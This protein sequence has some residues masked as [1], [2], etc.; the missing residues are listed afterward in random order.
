M[1]RKNDEVDVRNVYNWVLNRLRFSYQEK[2]NIEDLIERNDE[3]NKEAIE[4]FLSKE[5]DDVLLFNIED[6]KIVLKKEENIKFDDKIV[7][8]HKYMNGYIKD[9]NNILY[10]ILSPNILDTLKIMLLKVIY[11]LFFNNKNIYKNIC[12]DEINKFSMDFDV[13][14][15]ELN[16]FILILEDIKKVKK[17]KTYEYEIICEKNGANI[18]NKNENDEKKENSNVK[19]NNKSGNEIE[20]KIQKKKTETTLLTKYLNIIECLFNDMQHKIEEYKKCNFDVGPFIEIQYW[21]YKHRYL[22]FIIEELKSSEIKNIINN[23]NINNSNNEEQKYAYTFDILNKWR[24]LE[25]KIEN[26]Y[27]ESKDN[28]KY[29]ESI[30]QFILSLYLCNVEN[31]IDNIPSLLN[32]IKMIYLVARFY[33]TPNKLNN[34]FIKITNQLVLKC[35]NEIFFAKKKKKKNFRKSKRNDKKNKNNYEYTENSEKYNRQKDND[36]DSSNNI[37]ED[38]YLE[39]G[40]D[41]IRSSNFNKNKNNYNKKEYGYYDKHMKNKN[42]EMSLDGNNDSDE[43]MEKS[44]SSFDYHDSEN[45]EQSD[46]ENSY[47]IGDN[48]NEE[49]EG[50]NNKICGENIINMNFKMDEMTKDKENLWELDPDELIEKFEL[51]FKL[52]EKYKEEFNNIKT[53]F[54]NNSKNKSVNLDTQVIFCKMDLFCRRLKKLVD[55]FLCIKQFKELKKVKFNIIQNITTSFNKYIK[56]FKSKHIDDMLNYTDNYFDRDFVELRVY[57]SELE[58]DLQES[59][60]NLLNGSSNIMFSFFIFFKFKKCFMRDYLINFLHTKY[61][62]LLAQFLEILNSINNDLEHYKINL[63]SNKNINYLKNIFWIISIN[64][65]INHIIKIFLDENNLMLN[66]LNQVSSHFEMAKLKNAN[67]LK[68]F[69]KPLLN[70]SEKVV[71]SNGISGKGIDKN[72]CIDEKKE[73]IVCRNIF[74]E[75]NEE[76]LKLLEEHEKKKKNDTKKKV[77]SEEDGKNDGEK[78]CNEDKLVKIEESENKNKKIKNMIFKCSSGKEVLKLYIKIY[79]FIEEYKNKLFKHWVLFTKSVNSLNVTIFVKHPKTQNVTVNFDNRIKKIIREA[80]IFMSFNFEIPEDIKSMMSQESRIYTLYYKFYNILILVKKMKNNKKK[81]IEYTLNRFFIYIDKLIV[82]YA[83]KYTWNN[84]AVEDSVDN[85]TKEIKY[86]DENI[87]SLYYII[88][89]HINYNIKS[90]YK[91]LEHKNEKFNIN[92][93]KKNIYKKMILCNSISK[94]IQIAIFDLLNNIQYVYTNKLKSKITKEEITNTRNFYYNIFLSTLKKIYLK[95]IRMVINKWSSFDKFEGKKSDSNDIDK[96]ANSYGETNFI[97][98]LLLIH[99]NKIIINPSIDNIKEGIKKMINILIN[100]LIYVDNWISSDDLISK[101]EKDEENEKIKDEELGNKEMEKN[102]RKS[103]FDELLD[104]SSLLKKNRNEDDEFIIESNNCVCNLEYYFDFYEKIKDDKNI[105]KELIMLNE[106]LSGFQNVVDNFIKKFDKYKYIINKFEIERLKNLEKQ[107]NMPKKI[108]SVNNNNYSMPMGEII[109][110][111]DIEEHIKKGETSICVDSDSDPGKDKVVEKDNDK[112]EDVENCDYSSD[113]EFSDNYDDEYDLY[114]YKEEEKIKEYIDIKKEI[115]NIEN[116]Y[117]LNVFKFNL[118]KFKMY[119]VSIIENEAL[120]CANKIIY[121][122]KRKSDWLIKKMNGYKTKLKKN[123]VDIDSL[124]YVIDVIKKIHVFESNIDIVLN[125]IYE[126]L[127]ILEF[128]M[129]NFLKKQIDK[130]KNFNQYDCEGNDICGNNFYDNN[131]YQQNFGINLD[132]KELSNELNESYNKNFINTFNKLN[133]MKKKFISLYRIEVE[134]NNVIMSQFNELI[135]LTKKVE[136]EIQEK[137]SIMKSD[138]INNIYNFKHSMELFRTNFL[139]MNFKSKHA[140]PLTVFEILKRYKEEINILKKKYNSYYKGESIFGLKHQEHSDLFLS[141]TE[142]N[143]FYS[144]YDLYVQLKEKLNEWKNLKWNDGIIKIKELKEEILIFEKKCL[145]LP[146]NLKSIIIYKNLVKEIMYFKEIA[147]IIEELEKKTILKRHWIEIINILKDKKKKEINIKEKKV[148]KNMSETHKEADLVKENVERFKD[149]ITLKDDKN[150]GDNSNKNISGKNQTEYGEE[151]EIEILNDAEKINKENKPIENDIMLDDGYL[152]EAEYINNLNNLDLDNMDFL[153]KDLI[154]EYLLKKKDDILDICDSAEKEASIEEKINEQYKIW[155]ETCF[156]FSKWKNRDYACILVGSKVTE[157]QESLEESQILLNNINSTKYSKPFKNKLSILLNKLSDCSDIVERWIKVQMLW[158]SMESVFTSGDIARQMPIESKR[159]H[160]IDKDWINIINIAN[161]SSIVVE[162]CQSSMLKELLPNMQKGLESC[163]KSLESYLEGKR[164]KFPRFYFVSNLVLLKI[165]S[166][167]SDINIIQSELIKLFDAINYLTIKNIQNKKRIVCI[168]NKEKDDIET[169]ELANHVTIDGNIENWLILLEKEMQKAIKREC[170]LGVTNSAQLFKSMNLKEFCDKNIA[171]VS[172]ICLQVMWT[173]DIEK[174]IN[175]YNSEKNILKVTNKKINYIMSELVNICLSD[176]GTKFNRTKYETLVTIHVHQ[177]DLFNEISEKIKEHKIKTCTDFDWLKQTRI[178]YKPEKNIILIS[179]SDVDFIY[180]YEYLGIKER[181]CITP[182]TDRCYLTCAQALGLCYGGAPA[183]PAGTG[184]T[185]TVKDLGRTLGIYVIVTNCSNQ[186]KHKDMAKIFKGLCRSG[187]WGCFDEFNR[188]NLD[189]LSVVAMQIESIVTAKKQSLKHFLF[190]GDS[191]SINLNPSSAYFITMNPGY[192]GRQLLP[193]NLKIF[194]RF[195][196]MM[197]PDRQIIIKVKLASVGYLDIDNLSNKFK[198]LYNLCEEQLSKQK[199]Y[200]FGLRNILSVLRTAGDTKRTEAG[201]D[202][203][204]EILLMRTLRDMN[205][206]KLV[207]D[208]VLL[209]LSLLNDVFPKFHNITKKNYQ[210]IEENVLKIIKNKKLCAKKKWILKILQLYETSLVRHGFMLVGNTLTGKTEILNILTSALSNVDILTKIITLNPKSITSEHMYG[211]KDNLSEEWTPGI[212]ANIWERYNNS[213]LKYNTWIVCDG[214]VDAIWIENLNTVLDDN[215]IL[216][217]ANNDRI[218]M[219][220]NT[221][222]AFEV[223][224]LNNASPATVSRTGIVYISDNDLGYKPFIY[225]WLS[226]IKDINVYGNTL[227]TIFNKLFVFYLDKIKI[228]QFLRE[229]C[230]FVMEVSDSILVSQMINLLNSLL[231]QYIN[232]I[233]NFMYNEEDLNKIYFFPDSN[234]KKLLH[235]NGSTLIKQNRNDNLINDLDKS[236]NSINLIGTKNKKGKEIDLQKQKEQTPGSEKNKLLSNKNN[237]NKTLA[238]S[239]SNKNQVLSN[240]GSGKQEP[241]II[242]KGE[243][244]NT[245]KKY[246]GEI[247]KSEYISKNDQTEPNDGEYDDKMENTNNYNPGFETKYDQIKVEECEDIMIYCIVWGLCGLLEYAYRVKVHNYLLNNVSKLRSVLEKKEKLKKTKENNISEKLIYNNAGDN[248]VN[249]TNFK[250]NNS[251]ELEKN[252]TDKNDYDSFL[253]SENVVD[254]DE[255]FENDK[256]LIYDYYFDMQLRKLRK[257]NLSIFKMPKNMNTISAILIPTI[258]TDKVEHIIKLI[259]NI[260]I[261]SHNLHTYKSTLL[262][263][264]TGS[265]KTSI[266]LLYTSKQDK[267]TKRFNFS[268][269]TTPEKF[270]LFIESELERKTGKTYGPIGNTKSIIFIDDMSMPKINE[271]GDQ[272]TLELLRQLIE[273][274]GFYFLDKDKRGNFKKIIDLE[275][276]GCINHPGCGNNDIPKRL[277][278]KWFNINIP[279]YNLNSINTIYGTVLRTKF[280]KKRKFSEEIID[281]IDKIILCTIKL[282]GRLKKYLLPVPSRFHYLYTTRDLAKIFNSMLLCPHKTIDNSL[283]NFL[284]LWKHECERV[285]IDKLSRVEDKKYSLDQIKQIFK[286]YYPSYADI[287][288]K[289]IYFSYFYVSEKEEQEY[290]IEN[291]LIENGDQDQKNSGVAGGIGNNSGGSSNISGN[292]NGIKNLN[293]GIGGSR[294]ETG[295]SKMNTKIGNNDKGN[296]AINKND[297]TIEDNE[298][299]INNFSF[300]WMKKDYKIV[301]DFERLRYIAY[302]YMKEYNVNNVKKFDFVFFDDSLKHLIIIN[303][304]MQTPRGSSMLVGVGGSG[305]RSLTKLSVFISEQVLF[306]LNITKTYTKNLFFEDLKNLYISAGQM[307]KKTTFLLSDNDIE[308]NDFILEHVNSILSTGLVYGL[309]IKDEKEAIC[310]EMKEAYLKEMNKYNQSSK[311]KGNKKKQRNTKYDYTLDDLEIDNNSNDSQM[312]SDTSSLNN[313]DEYNFDTQYGNKNSSSIIS[314]KDMKNAG[315]KKKDEKVVNDFNVPSSAIFDYLLENFRNNLHI[316]LCFSPIHKEF[317]LRYQQ[318][319]CIYNC[320]TIDWFLKWPL[321]ALVNVSTAY[322]DNFNID[323]E[324]NLK[325]DF[326]NLFAIIH[327]K[328]SETCE[329]Y[330]ERMRRDTYVT[331]KSYLTFISLYKQMYVNKYDEIKCLKESVDIGLKKLNE[332]A[333]DVQKMRE[334]LTSEEEKLK[335][336]DEQMNILLEKVKNESLKAETQS[337]EVSKFRDKCIKEK[338]I[339]LKEQEEADKD[340]QEALPYLHEAEEAI[341]SITAK[342]ITELKSMKTPSDIIRIVFDGVLILLQGK[343]KE[344]KINMK[345][346]NKQHVEFIQDSFDEYA[347]P[348]MADIRFLNLLFDFSKNEKDNINE[349]TIELLKPYIESHFFKTQ[350]AKK[351]SAAAEGL[352]KW[353][354]A[355]AMYNQASKIVKPKMSYLK[356]QTGRLEDALKQLEKAEDSLLKAQLFVDNLKLDIENMCKKKKTLEETALKTKQRIEQANKLINGLASEKARWTEDSNNFSNIKKKIVGDVFMCSSFISYCGMFNTEFRNYL[357]NDVFYHY[358]KNVKNIPVSSNID[359]IKYVLSYDDTKICDWN[360]QKLPND[361]LSIENALIS[362]NSNKYGLL[363]DPQCQANNWIKNKEFQNNLTNQRCITTF[364]SPKFKDNLEF[365]LSEGKTLLIEN[366]EEYIDP[367]LDS[368]LEKQIIKKGKKNYVLIENNLIYFDDNF[369]LF[370]TTNLPNPSYSPEIYAK[371]CVIDFTVTVKGLEDQLLGRVLTEEQKHLEVSLKNIMIE[372][373][374]NTKSLQDLDK[375]LLYKLNTSSSN[376]IED[377]ELIEVLNNT[378]ALSKELEIKLKDS[379]EKKKEINEKR[380]QYRSVA[381]R[382]SILY[383]CIVD[384]TNVNYIYNTSLHQFL[385]QFDLSIQKAEKCQHIKKRVESILSTLTNLIISYMERCL[386]DQ[387]KIIFKLLISLKILLYD[388]IISNKDISFFLNP[389]SNYNPSNDITNELLNNNILNGNMDIKNRGKKGNSTDINMNNTTNVYLASEEKVAQISNGANS[390]KRNSNNINSEKEHIEECDDVVNYNTGNITMDNNTINKN[391]I[392]TN[393]RK[394]KNKGSSTKWLFKNEKLYKNINSLSYHSFG[395]DKNNRFFY[396]ILN[397]IQLNENIWKNYYDVLD[398]EN[399]D[400]PY[401]NDRLDSSSK[402][403]SFIKLCLIRCLREDRTILCANK[404]VDEV[405]NRNSDSIKHETLENIFSESS[406]RKPFLF[407]LSLA[408]DP[409]NM[410]DDFA[411]KFKKYPTDKI[412]MG[413]GQ[414]VIAKE[415]LKN[416]LISGNWLIL[417][418]CHLNK[419]FII[420]VYNMLKSLNEIEE[421]FRL[422]LTSE[423]DNEFPICILHGSIKISTSLSRGIKNNMRKIYKDM[424]KEDIIDKIDDEKYRKIIYALAYLHCVLCERKKFGPLGWCVPY[425]FS[426]TDLFASFLFIEKH[427]YS[428][429]LVNRPINWESIHYMLAEVQYGGKVTDDLDRELLLTYVQHY[430]SE[431]LFKSK[432]ENSEH[433]NNNNNNASMLNS[434]DNNV[435]RFSEITNFDNFIESLPNIDTPSV[436][437]LHNNAEITYRVNESRQVLNS[438]LE[439]QPRDIDH[440]DEKSMETVVK[441]I[442]IGILDKLPEDINI[443][444]IKKMIYRKNKNPQ[445]NNQTNQQLSVT[446]NLNGGAKNFNNLENYFYKNKNVSDNALQKS[447]LLNNTIDNNANTG[448]NTNTSDNRYNKNTAGIGNENDIILEN[449]DITY[450]ESNNDDNSIQYNFSP[451]QVFFLQEM[452]RIQKVINLVKTNLNDIINAIDGSKI[453]V[454][455]LQNDTKCIYSQSIPKHWIYDASET[456]I[457][458]VCNNLN[459]WL[460]ILNLRYEQIMNYFQ[461]GK[462]KSYWLPG[463]FNPQ[464]FLTSMKQ[465]ITRLNKKDQLSL[466]EVVLYADIKNFDI[467]KIKEYPEHGFYIHGLFIEGSKWN[468][469]E[470]K[471]EESSPKVLCENMPVIHITVVSN[472]D[473]KI[474]FIENNK[475]MFYNCPVYKYNVRTDKYFIFRIHLKTDV[476]PSIWK[477]RGTSL[478]CSKD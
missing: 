189:V 468:W 233:N 151:M 297:I 306:Q 184:K 117:I 40:V 373:K 252:M 13:Y 110:D 11:P 289:N 385:E 455:D 67:A 107:K 39:E 461:N 368:V 471:L 279:P 166:Q 260:P 216:T 324:D 257:F 139:K 250:D 71:N 146:K 478:L 417:Q 155:N 394:C 99:E 458:W 410:I 323:I 336:S 19:G 341:K 259:S 57:I 120:E 411:K 191:K 23:I 182:L 52:Q 195:I 44:D 460:N 265:A 467:E 337:I 382:G 68:G 402:I 106:K 358:T 21:R 60:I 4:N 185:E 221:K 79:K 236:D 470:G 381:L 342:D 2:Y 92:R 237:E 454:A 317:A 442:S 153:I 407:L 449:L 314:S 424:I 354:G 430:F 198:S 364:N 199:H 8:F 422:F 369:N 307:N 290:M 239:L 218:P 228:L 418:N 355:M 138:L 196:S 457:S 235:Q 132:K 463:F 459:Q 134:K 406:N 330:K 100:N 445:L 266:A 247:E 73:T 340:L 363:I 140:N 345:Y 136:E 207:H 447:L 156:R 379:N 390:N 42:V 219:T 82:P 372:L 66:S 277:K 386:F 377:E 264:S 222:I 163:Q 25:I 427:L 147:P 205:L 69:E 45:D 325:N 142:V 432:P 59:I 137:K 74:F 201:N 393:K 31:I 462:L 203:D 416:A 109:Y 181:L 254:M 433:T 376:L 301:F 251:G 210:L 375:Q 329:T 197:V 102:N 284:C 334:S 441:E 273:F 346:V 50:N 295:V 36:N 88:D 97:E 116:V 383:F 16:E 316:F 54:E 167:G 113:E 348:L 161:E 12:I 37:S 80:K 374:D 18:F 22:L 420:E 234:E 164:S 122:V 438:I 437:D 3:E 63:N 242:D 104:S 362:E 128:Y 96:T 281:N 230:K 412:S 443:D 231:V 378:K 403:S 223:E 51:C 48:M 270:Q 353:V 5:E 308:K 33:N 186:H 343:L 465:E 193:E 331:P 187:L 452:E 215:K 200:D 367:I 62:I 291:D 350:I 388:G 28:I 105:E 204:E 208:D 224:N 370:M 278:S 232:A 300:S 38:N 287:G 399:R 30:E 276:I 159:F 315:N 93:Q 241:K 332:A 333:M 149:D 172:L 413:E 188:I 263:G 123:I 46:V 262:L 469:Q 474:K 286:Q 351:A 338:D 126:M 240:T 268:S 440:G 148:K 162:C 238:L 32:S 365:C 275:Y 357:M 366:V 94:K 108:K 226:K 347:K 423:P 91:I 133:V 175:K 401:Y 359:V 144:L 304:I 261:R 320:V 256:C 227:F 294:I 405:L 428:T 213:N 274:Q 384:I 121:P 150:N 56:E 98:I 466:D 29:L 473:K 339:I 125:P 190:P 303:R 158:C 192:A 414:E 439:I 425:E 475:S 65:K 453:M 456:E 49:I 75:I 76:V 176:L 124:Y 135:Y 7:Y 280:N 14:I 157:I 141:I 214:P 168:N 245:Q 419:S 313:F 328:V 267:N 408:S 248:V 70:I 64:Y 47:S 55:L 217:L 101:F 72:C 448:K 220:D 371:C 171:Q 293:T 327:Q 83:V 84:Y 111:K 160:Q 103:I 352:C 249:T 444:D 178:Y 179:I 322:L 395:N 298:E 86:F 206:S 282:F 335:E 421:D 246:V 41:N 243:K 435:P 212:F 429:L 118:E 299:N 319:P 397:V 143:N 434:L 173:N 476:D 360:V 53:F 318:F 389:L 349:E 361:K 451:L 302:E 119:L 283:Y 271:W 446:S 20:N 154:N 269:V 225:S 170:K 387:H 380:E 272:S 34:L 356:I 174:C 58:S 89:D 17:Q 130:F 211:V 145:Q 9:E 288:D 177:R 392:D 398:I 15:K 77:V 305:K 464:G 296:T 35:K 415:K 1:D 436:L 312:K 244:E 26:E 426:I 409:T 81:D 400:I 112:N 6:N 431:D 253:E 152:D 90:L 169:V 131:G 229:N 477:L 129:N 202:I 344:P 165:L 450:W 10:G 183:G 209:F 180:S 255:D 87:N 391:K 127:D 24:E 404:F 472:K 85:L 78:E 258:E 326:Y 27:N 311:M 396:D 310:S 43:E 309:F 61:D 194:F 321:E 115:N 95:N 292:K 285:L 114:I